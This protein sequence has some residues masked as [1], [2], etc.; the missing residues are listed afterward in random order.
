MLGVENTTADENFAEAVPEPSTEIAEETL[1]EG[2]YCPPESIIGEPWFICYRIESRNGR[3]VKVP[4]EPR[5]D[6]SI[7]N[8]DATNLSVGTDYHS[9][10][11][12]VDESRKQCC[13]ENGFRDALDGVGV[14]LHEDNDL[15]G[16]DMD[17]VYDAETGEI[18]EWA[19]ELVRAVG[20]YSEI[21][22]SS[23][24]IH[25]LAEGGLDEDFGNRNDEIGLEMYGSARFFTLTCRSLKTAPTEIIEAGDVV[26]R[27][28]R[29][30][31]GG[32]AG[33]GSNDSQSITELDTE[34]TASE[35]DRTD[36]ELVEKAR[37]A[38]SD[39]DRLWR[40]IRTG[41]NSPSESEF[42]MAC[43]LAYW[44]E[45][46]SRQ[47]ERLMRQSGLERDKFDESR[48]SKTYLEMTIENAIQANGR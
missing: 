2:A 40:G 12:S 19:L 48:G 8:A 1:K 5:Q 26:R 30:W 6:G 7:V 16:I 22:P 44:C 35:L 38:D 47:M 45:S 21:S 9:A 42:S 3:T 4:K 11:G 29:S 46:D 13:G 27:Y 41:Y 43:K 28:Q 24:G 36:E 32:T 20:S 34:P 15:V 31:I 18:E 39:F 10:L 37:S 33:P 25:V 23:D 14:L 17:H